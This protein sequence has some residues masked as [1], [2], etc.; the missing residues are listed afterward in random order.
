MDSDVTVWHSVTWRG[1]P[2]AILVC[3]IEVGHA[4]T[5]AGEVGGTGSR[6]TE[7]GSNQNWA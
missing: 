6:R 3:S 7:D 1:L 5:A 2:F 4:G